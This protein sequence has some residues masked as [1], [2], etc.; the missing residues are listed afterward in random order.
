[1][2]NVGEEMCLKYRKVL[3]QDLADRRRWICNIYCEEQTSNVEQVKFGRNCSAWF[4]QKWV[5]MHLN[6]Y[7][8]G[9]I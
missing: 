8:V 9:R 1:V 7:W 5:G 4:V 3:V 6:G 2:G